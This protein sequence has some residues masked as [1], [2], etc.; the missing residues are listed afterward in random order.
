M[1]LHLNAIQCNLKPAFYKHD[2]MR[3]WLNKSEKKKNPIK[4]CHCLQNRNKTHFCLWFF[5]NKNKHNL[6]TATFLILVK[7]E[8]ILWVIKH[9]LL[10]TDR[11][12]YRYFAANLPSFKQ[13]QFKKTIPLKTVT[14][15]S[16]VK[17]GNSINHKNQYFILAKENWLWVKTE[18]RSQYFFLPTVLSNKMSIKR[19]T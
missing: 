1:A 9:L 14:I 16:R 13:T 4:T 8:S 11:H 3:V 18:G 7:L 10:R 5:Q 15:T 6:F 19:S 17:D 12:I 2:E